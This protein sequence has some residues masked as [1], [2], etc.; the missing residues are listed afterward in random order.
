METQVSYKRLIDEHA[1]IDE[2]TQL[3]TE[4]VSAA[5][6]DVPAVLIALSDLSCELT[7]HLAHEDSFIYPRMIAA[8][9][10]EL[11]ES[12]SA[13]VHDFAALRSDWCL[14]LTEWTS[15]AIAGD[16]QTFQQET[17]AI[18]ARLATRVWAEDE[19]LYPAAFRNGLIPL[20]GTG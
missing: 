1:R 7:Q 3:L 12:A 18:L 17:R 9:D 2:R 11:A 8:R 15:D 10:T 19:L 20:R 4:L 13:F 5:E 6:P 16:W 14:Y